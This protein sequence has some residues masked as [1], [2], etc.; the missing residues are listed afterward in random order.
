MMNSPSIVILRRLLTAFFVVLPLCYVTSRV[1]SADDPPQIRSA[2]VLGTSQ[3]DVTSIEDDAKAMADVLRQLGFQVIHENNISKAR[4]EALVRQWVKTLQNGGVGLFYYA[5]HGAQINGVNYLR[6]VGSTLNALDDVKSTWVN[7]DS[8]LLALEGTPTNVRFVLLDA[9]RD[10]PILAKLAA[11][12]HDGDM[13]IKGLAEPKSPPRNTLVSFATGPGKIARDEGN[14]PHSPYTTAL[15]KYIRQPGL[16]IDELF[17]YVGT[18]VEGATF[19]DQVPWINSSF[20]PLFY[21]R[22]P[23]YIL[24]KS[25]EVDD[26]LLVLLNGDEVFSSNNAQSAGKRIPLKNGQNA[27]VIKVYNQHTFTGGVDL[28]DV[29][30][31]LPPGP[32]HLPEG[33]R[34]RFQLFSLQQQ[35]LASFY[36]CED[37]P[38]KN[39]PH[40]GHMFT[41]ATA[42]ILVDETTGKVSL[43]N[44]DDQVWKRDEPNAKGC[45]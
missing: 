12:D 39:G 13:W 45:S 42:D 27:L 40:H 1:C 26:E 7:L 43:A 34:Y 23:A 30:P 29:F 22:E 4:I 5:G 15:L 32:G 35:P 21:F 16:S 10:N 38:V 9:C 3:P 31:N 17:R 8:L 25:G 37:R 33:W 2:L 19:D 41:V 14:R 6:P 11:Q 44:V 18:Y 28:S 24:A 20:R 36:A